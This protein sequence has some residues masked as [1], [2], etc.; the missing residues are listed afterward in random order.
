MRTAFVCGSSDP[1][2]ANR[3]CTVSLDCTVGLD[4]MVGLPN[5]GAPVPACSTVRGRP[6]TVPSHAT[7]ASRFAPSL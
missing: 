5:Q 1:T 3:S 2:N 7:G 4:C 6:R